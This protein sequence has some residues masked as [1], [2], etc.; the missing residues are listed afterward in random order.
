MRKPW[1]SPVEQVQCLKEKGIA[2]DLM[3]EAEA[4]RYLAA[5][6]NYFRV[7]SY[8]HGFPRV[9]GGENDGKYIN[10]DFAMLK[11]L[12]IIDYLLRQA[13]LPM[14]IDVEHFAKMDL[15]SWI[16]DHSG[17]GYELVHS[18]LEAKTH[19]NP[20]GEPVCRIRDE[21]NRGNAGVYT[22][23]MIERYRDD[24]MPVWV[25][26]ELIPFGTFCQFWKHC[27]WEG[28]DKSMEG[29]YYLLQDVK[30][31]W[32]ACGHN[33]CILNGLESGTA[34]HR[35]SREVIN[36]VRD[37]GVAEVMRKSKLSNGRIQHITSALYLHHMVASDGV[38]S[39]TGE[40]LNLLLERMDK[41]K[42]Y[43]LKCDQIRTMF[44]YMRILVNAWYGHRRMVIDPPVEALRFESCQI[45]SNTALQHN[46]GA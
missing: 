46:N 40:R 11:D 3:T 9:V 7:A 21:I 31:L 32:N 38:C 18:F 20:Q 25:F 29:R 26:L 5:N 22:D 15:L 36:A 41:H 6:S 28:G 23:K 1:L 19:I 2:F 24:E 17:D 44:E 8:R 4:E 12:S 27:S 34:K 35:A 39:H 13:L 43:Y 45:D 42:D 30:N 10:L 33:N 16:E 14:T 37:A